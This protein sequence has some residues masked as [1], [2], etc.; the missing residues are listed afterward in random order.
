MATHQA[1]GIVQGFGQRAQWVVAA[2]VLAGSVGA[3]VRSS[4]GLVISAKV[5]TVPG[6]IALAAYNKLRLTPALASGDPVARRTLRR[7]I[8]AEFGLATVVLVLT[9]TLTAT[10]PPMN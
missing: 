6:L 1:A 3:L 4:W 9:A 2:L 10:P 8:A 5:L 7:T